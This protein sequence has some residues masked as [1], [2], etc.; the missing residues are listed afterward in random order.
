MPRRLKK[1]KACGIKR[2]DY[3]R[4]DPTLC[5][6]CSDDLVAKRNYEPDPR[7]NLPADE[8]TEEEL[9]ALICLNVNSDAQ[10]VMQKRIERMTRKIQD[11]WSDGQRERRAVSKKKSCQPHSLSSSGHERRHRWMQI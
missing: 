6:R 3:D 5:G 11:N 7:Y 4:D 8:A 10:E 9:R 1:C 2:R